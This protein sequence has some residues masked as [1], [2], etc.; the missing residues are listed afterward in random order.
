MQWDP[1]FY[2]FERTQL[3]AHVHIMHGMLWQQAGCSR[4][5]RSAVRPQ[6]ANG[7]VM[8]LSVQRIFLQMQMCAAC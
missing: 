1:A 5:S 7:P 4:H 8:H 3:P 6:A 2:F